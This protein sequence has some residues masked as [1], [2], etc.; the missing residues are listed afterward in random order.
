MLHIDLPSRA[1]I[2]A[3]AAHR[4][5]P[6]VSIYLRTTPV[7]QDAQIDRIELKNLLREAVEQMEAADTPKRSVWPIEEA[8]QG[9]IDDD[10]V[11]GRAGEQPGDL[12]LRG[13]ARDVPAAQQAHQHGRG[14]G[15]GPPQAAA[16]GDDLRQPGLR[17]RHRHRRLPAGRGLG[18]PAAARGQGPGPAARL[19]PG[20]RQAQP[21]RAGRDGPDRLDERERAADALRPR[22]RR[23]AAPAADRAGAAADRRR[24]RADGVDLPRRLE[25][26]AHRGAGDRGQRRQHARPRAGGRRA[27]RARRDRRRADR[28]TRRRSTPRAPSRAAPPPT[29]PRPPGRRPSAPSTR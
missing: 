7:T 12:R 23:G 21:P 4:A 2:E 24:R 29:S 15:P 8:V 19:Q 3:L 9:L 22:G 27:R 28:R 18:R 1:E 26:P 13:S 6:T 14:L 25:L 5:Q 11:L 20:A 10:G 16:A 17:A